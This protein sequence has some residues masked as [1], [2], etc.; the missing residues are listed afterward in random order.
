[1]EK[2]PQSP[3]TSAIAPTA[4]TDLLI[5]PS[6]PL[7]R[8]DAYMPMPTHTAMNGRLPIKQTSVRS[9]KAMGV[10]KIPTS[11][12]IGKGKSQ[13]TMKEV[14]V[15]TVSEYACEDADITLRLRD[16]FEPDL[17][18]KQVDRVFWD[19]EMPLLPVLVLL[20][21]VRI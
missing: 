20:I 10:K 4:P 8:S 11:E 17:V 7:A 6:T 5:A 12:L 3:E 9:S 21:T 15:E 19:V 13:I 2:N 16:L 1:M 18:E 14:P